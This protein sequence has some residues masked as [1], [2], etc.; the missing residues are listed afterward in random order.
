VCEGG[1]C[2]AP[3]EEAAETLAIALALIDSAHSGRWVDGRQGVDEVGIGQGS[4]WRGS[5]TH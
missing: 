1:A 5:S 2:P 3:P 4:A